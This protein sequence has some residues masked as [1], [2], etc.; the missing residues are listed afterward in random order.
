MKSLFGEERKL[1]MK[2][3]D[4]LGIAKERGKIYDNDLYG[5]L[6]YCYECGRADKAVEMGDRVSEL[7]HRMNDRIQNSRYHKMITDIVLND[8]EL[9]GRMGETVLYLYDDEYCNDICVFGNDD[10]GFNEIFKDEK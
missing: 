9:K 10:V 2:K 3:T 6:L 4:F 1:T 7:L 5:L 8:D